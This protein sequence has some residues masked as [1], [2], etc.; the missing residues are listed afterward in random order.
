MKKYIVNYWISGK[1]Q[2]G[3]EFISTGDAADFTKKIISEMNNAKTPVT[4]VEVYCKK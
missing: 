4:K 2:N 1:K 3:G